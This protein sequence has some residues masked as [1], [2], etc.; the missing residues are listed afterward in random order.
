MSPECCPDC[1]V[2]LKGVE[3]SW[4]KMDLGDE[5][6]PCP[7]S[8]LPEAWGPGLALKIGARSGSGL[9]PLQI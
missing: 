1:Q 2:V 7:C 6:W 8:E 3:M 4:L 9:R 5:L